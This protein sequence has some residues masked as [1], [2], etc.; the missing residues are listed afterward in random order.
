MATSLRSADADELPARGR[1]ATD[2]AALVEAGRVELVGGFRIHSVEPAGDRVRPV[3]DHFEG[4]DVIQAQD[5][6]VE[7]DGV[8]AA[9]GFRPDHAIAA[10]LRLALEPALES[11]AALGALI[12]PN[13]HTCGTVPVHGIAE[14]AHPEAGYVIVGMKSYGRAPTFLLATGYQ[15]VRS[16]VAALAGD[17]AGALHHDQGPPGGGPVRPQPQPSCQRPAS[18]PTGPVRPWSAQRDAGFAGWDGGGPECCHLRQLAN[19]AGVARAGRA[20][21]P[22]W[23]PTLPRRADVVLAGHATRVPDRTVIFGPERTTTVTATYPL[24]RRLALLQVARIPRMCLI[25]MRS[26]S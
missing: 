12:D 20:H 23:S 14:L 26:R 1:L 18:P 13:V 25:R 10:E 19:E 16:V 15:Q 11:A 7:A 21:R 5:L 4:D 17:H 9:T 22:S 8:I 2:L 3:G 24:S 6:V